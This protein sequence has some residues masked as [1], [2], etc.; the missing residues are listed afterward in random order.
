MCAHWVIILGM[1]QAITKEGRLSIRADV[2]QKELLARA[3]RVQHMNVSQFV[4]QVAL[5]EAQKVIE[6]ETKIVVSPEEYE[7]L[8]RKLEEPPQDNLAL[9][10][11]FAE[12]PVWDD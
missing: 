6:R 10:Q 1:S 12:K 9:R 5:Q 8:M 11:L 7:W 4:L 2:A 3:A